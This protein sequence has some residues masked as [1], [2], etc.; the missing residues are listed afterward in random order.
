MSDRHEA[1][2][3]SWRTRRTMSAFA[4]SRAAEAASKEALR[5]YCEEQGWKLA[6]FEG[7]TGSPRTG[8]IDAIAFRLARRNADLLDVR[9]IQ[10]KGGKAGVSGSEIAR[11]KKA[12]AGAT[13]KWLIAAFD[14]EALH[15]LPDDATE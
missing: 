14:G 3:K 4:K 7:A 13:V 11:L 12:A 5:L 15:L 1:A 6:F 10:L 8:I 2:L 9:L